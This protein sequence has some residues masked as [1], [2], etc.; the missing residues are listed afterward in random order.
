MRVADERKCPE[1]EMEI[2]LFENDWVA[3][4]VTYHITEWKVALD[5]RYV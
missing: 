5:L 4:L 3:S 1:R 2:S